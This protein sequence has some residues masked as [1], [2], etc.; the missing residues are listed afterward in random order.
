MESVARPSCTQA[1][2]VKWQNAKQDIKESVVKTAR[3]A[4]DFFLEYGV[5]IVGV[6]AIWACVASIVV[7][8]PVA[9]AVVAISLVGVGVCLGMMVRQ[10]KEFLRLKKEQAASKLS[11]S[12][13][14]H[15]RTNSDERGQI[16]DGILRDL[17]SNHPEILDVW[18]RAGNI[19]TD[20]ERRA[21]VL[22]WVEKRGTCFG[23]ACEWMRV[24]KENP[25]MSPKEIVERMDGE[26]IIRSQVLQKMGAEICKYACT[27]RD[28]GASYE[29]VSKL[30][31]KAHTMS[32]SIGVA[33]LRRCQSVVH[34]DRIGT[35]ILKEVGG[36]GK[37]F[38]GLVQANS[39]TQERGHAVS[40]SCQNGR[41]AIYD[42]KDGKQFSAGVFETG[43]FS[44][45][46]RHLSSRLQ[47]D[48][49]YKGA[50]AQFSMLV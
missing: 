2:F 43:D 34:I 39:R 3:I 7:L 1:L 40:V 8:P 20:A 17:K 35:K 14:L 13:L 42:S 37:P 18:S 26:R 6:L 45:F 49:V 33:T 32:R 29:S 15:E 41:Y 21:R 4:K 50:E 44:S 38:T 28:H 16:V 24:S 47:S 31:A 27:L 19:Q 46:Q 25:G 22:E 5:F 23:Q 11:N 12:F 30:G 9:I 48:P 10:V 36:K